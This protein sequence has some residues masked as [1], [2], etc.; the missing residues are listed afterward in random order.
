MSASMRISAAVSFD[1]LAHKDSS[2]IIFNLSKSYYLWLQILILNFEE[3]PCDKTK[4]EIKLILNKHKLLHQNN[5]L[6]FKKKN[7]FQNLFI[8]KYSVPYLICGC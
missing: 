6:W 5:E 1:K 3:R 4:K 7:F 8:K 2:H